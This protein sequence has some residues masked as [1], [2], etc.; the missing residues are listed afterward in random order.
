MAIDYAVTLECEP[1]RHFGGGDCAKG[2][3]DILERLKSRN[4]ASAFRQ[5][6]GNK[7]TNQVNHS[8]TLMVSVHGPN[9]TQKKVTL[10]E[11]DAEAKLLEE[12]APACSG[13]RANFLGQPYG[14]FGAIN[15]PIPESGEAWLLGR[16]QPAG[17]LGA[18]LCAEFMAEFGVKGESVRRMRDEGLFEARK[19]GKV[20]LSKS[21]LKSVSLSAD[22]LLETIFMAGNP[23]DPGHCF[24]I[25]VWLGAIRVDGQ[26]PS[27]PDDQA[28]IRTLIGLQSPQAKEQHT[29]LE[30]GPKMTAKAPAEFQFL[31]TALYLCWVHAV[32]LY[33]SP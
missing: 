18:Q 1:K 28:V 26:I 23:L 32:P 6:T 27:S 14:C 5:L 20:T 3:L 10:A 16:M 7:G 8:L 2:T 30:L 19:A 24:G 15:Y 21:F 13:C 4:R 17:S 29:Q 22:Q 12:R 11:L 25:L 9:P 31:V 33:I